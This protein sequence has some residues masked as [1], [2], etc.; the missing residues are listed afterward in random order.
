M[1]SSLHINR[2][3]FLS[4]FLIFW[5]VFRKILVYKISRNYVQW[6][7]SG[8]IRTDGRTDGQTD[9]TKLIV[10]SQSKTNKMQ[11]FTIYLFL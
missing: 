3:S 2:P 9:K 7:P 6:G 8:S 11:R 5:T 4:D 10:P 1:S